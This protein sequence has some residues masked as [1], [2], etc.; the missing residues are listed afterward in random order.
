MATAGQ[1][2]VSEEQ[3]STMTHLAGLN[4]SKEEV[5]ELKPMYDLYQEYIRLVH[6]ID[7]QAEEIGL[8]FHPDWPSA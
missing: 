4:M 6:S 2:N 5:D 1:Q 7:L 8:T 3:F